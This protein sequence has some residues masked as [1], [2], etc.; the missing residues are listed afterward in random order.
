ME[1]YFNYYIARTLV[2]IDQVDGTLLLK[3]Q[4]C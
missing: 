3:I 2:F 4:L 1:K